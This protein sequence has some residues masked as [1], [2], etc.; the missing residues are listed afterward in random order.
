[1]TTGFQE[2]ESEELA[3]LRA[4]DRYKN[5]ELLPALL[6]RL[7]EQDVVLLEC[8]AVLVEICPELSGRAMA[9]AGIDPHKKPEKAQV[10]TGEK[11]DFWIIQFG[12]QWLV[13]RMTFDVALNKSLACGHEYVGRYDSLEEAES[14]IPKSKTYSVRTEV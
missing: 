6:K 12:G 14:R 1:M 13:Y 3:R 11:L 10:K 8:A 4:E 9:A 5:G 2:T 7:R